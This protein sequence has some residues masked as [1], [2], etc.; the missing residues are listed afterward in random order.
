MLQ[1]LGRASSSNVQ[2]VM[3]LLAEMKLPCERLDFGGS[4]GGN[5]DRPYLQM[6]PNGL[7]PTLIDGDWIVWESNTILRYLANRHQP[8]AFYPP[9]ARGRSMVERW[10]DWQLGTLNG[11]IT[12]LFQAIVRTPPDRR[13]PQL[14]A[15]HRERTAASLRLLDEVLALHP[16]VAGEH[17]TLADI[18]LGASVYRWFELPVD[19]EN[20]QSL[21]RWYRDMQAR[22][23]FR[24]HVM[25]GLA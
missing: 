15:Q 17:L 4:F 21:Q 10:M 23:G 2:K 20:T 24:E 25:V 11:G 14:I 18:A 5:K 9:D 16:F 12:P 22:P 8:N 7:V 19:R 3:W 13:D 1:V 6:N